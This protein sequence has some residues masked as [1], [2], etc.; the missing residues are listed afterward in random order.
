MKLGD[1]RQTISKNFPYKK[2][3]DDE[4]PEAFDCGTQLNWVDLKN[5]EVGNVF[6]YLRDKIVFQ[7]N[8][9]D[10]RYQT[11]EGIKSGS[12]PEEVKKYYKGLRSYVLSS[13]TSE[14]FG[15][16][17]LIYWIDRNKGI[18]FSF[19]YGKTSHRRYLY[20][21]IVFK[22]NAEVCPIDDSTHSPA[23]HELMPYSLEST[24]L[25]PD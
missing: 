25:K 10:S 7:A 5:P 18:A 20:E 1:D 21:I 2:N 12:S 17:P 22:P 16:R 11:A 8:F 13:N 24:E 23:K 9:A 3:V 4:T 19:A 14:A 15:M 6:I